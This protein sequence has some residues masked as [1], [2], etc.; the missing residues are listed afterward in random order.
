[1][2]GDEFREWLEARACDRTRRHYI[3][4]LNNAPPPPQAGAEQEGREP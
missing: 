1:M 4:L 3:L 2:A